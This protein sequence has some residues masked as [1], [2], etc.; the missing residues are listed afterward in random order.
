[1]VSA[2]LTRRLKA[3]GAISVSGALVFTDYKL[4]PGETLSVDI[5]AAEPLCDCLPEKGNL[6]ILFENEGLL[7]V[8]KPAGIIVHP[9]RSKNSGTLLNFAAGYLGTQKADSTGLCEREEGEATPIL[10]AAPCHGVNRLDR[11]TSGVVLIAKNS[12]MKALASK[13]LSESSAVKEYLALVYGAMQENGVIDAPIRRLMERNMLRITSQDGQRAVTHYE[14]IKIISA[15]DS[16]ATLLR[17]R[18]ETGRTHQIRVHCLHAGHPVLGDRLYCTDESRK[19][20]QAF[21]VEA[22]ALHAHKL[23]FEEPLSGNPVEITAPAPLE[24]RIENLQ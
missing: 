5:T 17:L 19:A 16:S 21:G 10:T 4:S 2:T 22:Q 3:A 14:P 18:L 13:A 12:Y 23:A 15:G 20:S 9:S 11:D 1:M 8:N 6:E 24:L 7:A